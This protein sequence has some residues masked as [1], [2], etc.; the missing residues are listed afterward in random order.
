M[1]VF[2]FACASVFMCRCV[3]VCTETLIN[4]PYLGK[5]RTKRAP[6]VNTGSAAQIEM[7]E[8]EDL[9]DCFHPDGGYNGFGVGPGRF[10]PVTHH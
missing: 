9:C 6:A 7:E 2:V 3:T 1:C 5:W 8:N 4:I 10:P